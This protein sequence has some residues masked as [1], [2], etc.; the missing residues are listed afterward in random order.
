MSVIRAADLF[1]GAGGSSTG[2]RRVADALGAKL[3]LTAVNHWPLAMETHAANHPDARHV[4]EDVGVVQPRKVCGDRLD[5]LWASPACTDHSYAGGDKTIDASDQSRAS[6]WA[7]LRWIEELRPAWVIVENVPAYTKWGPIGR[8]GK[9]LKSRAGETFHAWLAAWRSLGF[10][11]E[12]RELVAA[13]YGEATTRP[14]FFAIGRFD[15]GRSRGPIPWPAITHVPADQRT[16]LFADDVQT[17]RGAREIID[18]SIRGRSIFGRPKPL[19]DNTLAKIAEG[20]ARYWG[21]DLAPFLIA[22][23]HG[24]RVCGLDQPLPTITTAKGGAFSLVEPF[25]IGQQSGSVPRRVSEP[26]PTLSTAGAIA[27]VEPFLVAYYSNGSGREP[28]SIRKPLPTLTTTDRFGLVEAGLGDITLRMLDLHEAAA[29]MVFPS[30]YRFA[31][32]KRDGMK[33]VGNAVSVRQAAALW[34]H[35]VEHVLGRGRRAA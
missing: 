33:Q 24:G 32:N 3:E 12:W 31:G 34:Q 16:G 20:A 17:W 2:L 19:A 26:A 8:N 10:T 28:Q 18:W 1:A 23:E 9:K 27:L 22:H 21:V 7:I 35:P 4:P 13:D 6:A 30:G 15:G 5:L 11:I 25:V 29:A 14:R